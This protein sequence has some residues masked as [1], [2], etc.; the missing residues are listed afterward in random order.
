MEL[1][2]MSPQENDFIKEIQWNNEELKQEITATMQEY[3]SLAFTEENIK[4]A[5]ADRAKLNKLR[6]AFE[7]ERKKIKKQCME[8]YTKFEKQ[9]KEIVSLIDEPIALIDSQIKEVDD[10]KKAQKQKDI[11]ELF[12]SLGFQNFVTLDKIFDSKW[13]NASVAMS[14][15]EEQMKSQMFQI[16]HELE[17]IRKLP[18]FAFE[19]KELYKKTLDMNQAIQEGQRL[20]EI[21]KRKLAYE[22]EQ[23]AKEEE[24]KRQ[25]ELRQ[26]ET[27]TQKAQEKSKSVTESKKEDNSENSPE[28]QQDQKTDPIM[29]IDFRAWGTREQLMGIRQ[30]MLD[31]NI[32]FGKAE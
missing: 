22:A 18:E 3:K 10:Q 26:K 5:K 21:Q 11:E 29:S 9:V 13:L 32:K 12:G 27:A 1:R 7:D 23:K 2:I 25:T 24:L 30:Y 28:S 4:D 15:I 31:N 19:A 6:T 20:A 17:T 14:K 8:P 16:G